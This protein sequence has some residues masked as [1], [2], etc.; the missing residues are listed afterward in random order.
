MSDLLPG[1]FCAI[2]DRRRNLLEAHECTDPIRADLMY[3]RLPDRPNTVIVSLWDVRAADDLKIRYDFDRDGWVISMDLTHDDNSGIIKTVK[4]D[5]E[6]AFIPAW[7]EV[8]EE[9]AD[10]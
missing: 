5:Q 8:D 3:P 10:A 9:T 7:N 2:C 6:V 1:H 4:E